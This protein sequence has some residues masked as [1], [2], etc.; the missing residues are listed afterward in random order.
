MTRTI[1]RSPAYNRAATRRVMPAHLCNPAWMV[2]L[3]TDTTFLLGGDGFGADDATRRLAYQQAKAAGINPEGK[4]Y[5]PQLARK[6]LRWKDPEAWVS[7]KDDVRRVCESRGLG[8]EGAVT[9]KAREPEQGI[10]DV[11]YSVAPDIVERN[12]NALVENTVPV[13]AKSR[14]KLREDVNAKLMPASGTPC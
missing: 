14:T 8:C 1:L 13:D 10:D 2:N 11:P 9:V 5:S 7:S 4:R 3:S 12:V 6:G